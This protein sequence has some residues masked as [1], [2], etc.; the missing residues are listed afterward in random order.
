NKVD[1]EEQSLVG[2]FNN[3]KIYEAEVKGS[4]PSSQNTQ[5][6]DFLSS[7][8]TDSTNKSVNAAPSIYAASSKAKVSILLN[9]DSLSDSVIYSFFASQSNSPQLDNE[10][11]KQID[12]DNLEEM[13]LK[14]RMA[15][16]TMRARRFLKRTGRN[17][18][19]NGTDTIGFNMSKIECYNWHKR[20][21]FAMEC[22]S[23]KDNRN[24]EITKRTIPAETS[25]KILSKLLESQG[26]DK[27][28][29]GFNSQVFRRQVSNCEELYSHN[30]DN[31][32]P[33]NLENNSKNKPIKDMSKTH[34]PDASIVE[35][36]IS[37]SKDETKIESVPK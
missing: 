34:M 14:W 19:A 30:S 10:D 25:S 11:L 35:D 37:D 1:L 33:K 22:R 36:W 31:R 26:S 6:I 8:N 27:T 20:G 23:S 24:K 16:L 4:S 21:H 9:V 17:L 3:F 5:N 15:M 18:C 13:D 29:L 28:G 12:L 7:N 2:L 32:V